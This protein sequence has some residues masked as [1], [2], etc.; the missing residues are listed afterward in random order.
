MEQFIETAAT[1]KQ[2]T[3]VY[4]FMPNVDKIR[5]LTLFQEEG[6]P[7]L[8]P[9]GHRAV[10]DSPAHVALLARYVELFKRDIFPTDTLPRGYPGATER[11]AARQLAMI[12]I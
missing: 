7:V 6:L 5:L 8:S 1:I 12:H 10:F 9:D 3:G 4:G 11:S 2:K